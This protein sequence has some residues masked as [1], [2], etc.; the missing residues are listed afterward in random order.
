M[1]ST[2]SGMQKSTTTGLTQ[3][4]SNENI[5]SNRSNQDTDSLYKSSKRLKTENQ[6]INSNILNE[7]ELSNEG[8]GYSDDGASNDVEDD[9]EKSNNNGNNTFSSI[10]STSSHFDTK[11]KLLDGSTY[12]DN[13]DLKLNNNTGSNGVAPECYVKKPP[14]SYVTLIGMAIK[15][16]SMKRLTLSEIYEFICKQF[17]YY[18]RNKKGW[19]NSIRHN[20]SLNEC[21]I[22]FPR[23]TSSS[24]QNQSKNYDASNTSSDRKGCYW[25]IDPNCFEMF[26]DNLINYKRRRRV[27]KKQQANISNDNN[28]THQS[29]HQ[30]SS[31]NYQKSK[32]NQNKLKSE[33]SQFINPNKNTLDKDAIKIKKN[34]KT[35]ILFENSSSRSSSSPSLSTSSSSS[36]SSTSSSSFPNNN[37]NANN[38]S[39]ALNISTDNK[40]NQILQADSLLK[41]QAAAAQLAAL[42]TGFLQDKQKNSFQAN[43]FAILQQTLNLGNDQQQFSNQQTNQ[44][45]FSNFNQ[46]NL[47]NYSQVADINNKLEP[48]SFN[49]NS[50]LTGKPSFELYAAAAALAMQK[51]STNSP[52]NNNININN[53]NNSQAQQQLNNLNNLN[54]IFNMD[55]S[56]NALNTNNNQF[57]LN[58]LAALANNNNLQ[59]NRSG[60]LNSKLNLVEL[61][62]AAQVAAS[63]QQQQLQYSNQMQQ[64]NIHQHQQQ[65]Q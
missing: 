4:K 25:T 34:G 60:D 59:G 13:K 22:K 3:S 21:F 52:N 6:S 9:F 37:N 44:I 12:S 48:S 33:K 51:N 50:W 17:P 35:N 64:I 2:T 61:A 30:S 16:S 46:N 58:Q 62:A 41:H 47:F 56:A 5:K 55:R 38:N 27:V 19:Q 43:P 42:S 1:Q 45:P 39:N 14:Y 8:C 23:S 7:N 40:N 54:N 63:L 53:N 31:N 36:S 24:I 10:S 49:A 57:L 18:E 28:N 11:K 65:N 32:I 26:S 20:L 15:S 29:E